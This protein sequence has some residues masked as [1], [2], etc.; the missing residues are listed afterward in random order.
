M[1]EIKVGDR[2]VRFGRPREVLGIEGKWAWI[3]D[4]AGEVP[5]T[6]PLSDLTLIP[7]EPRYKVGDRIRE[8]DVGM[9]GVVI[10]T[11]V[12]RTGKCWCWIEYDA[13]SD[14]CHGSEEDELSPAC[15]KGDA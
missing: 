14:F 7:P 12:S 15:C 8:S 5:L 6:C 2:V 1:S 10:G 11:H 13:D 3:K 4:E 9:S